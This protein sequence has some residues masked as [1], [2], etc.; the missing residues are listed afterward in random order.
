[1]HEFLNLDRYAE[2]LGDPSKYFVDHFGP[3]PR[4]VE[5]ATG[6][7]RYVIDNG[8][9]LRPYDAYRAGQV[10]HD[11]LPDHSPQPHV[12]RF[13]PRPPARGV[14]VQSAPGEISIGI[15]VTPP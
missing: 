13:G 1:M 15:Q 9:Q 6:M 4:V 14:D 10:P 7:P 2:V 8:G 3:H 12:Y 5:H 11:E